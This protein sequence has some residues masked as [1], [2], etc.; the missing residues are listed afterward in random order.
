MVTSILAAS[1][2]E[3]IQLLS[4]P[5]RQRA[6]LKIQ[7]GCTNFCSYCII[8]YTRGPLRSRPLAGL[9]R[10]VHKLADAQFKEI[11]LTGIH[12]GA[13]GRDLIDGVTLADVVQAV[14]DVDGVVRIRLG[15]LE[16]IEV[17]VEMIELFKY[18]TKLCHHLHLPL[19]SGSNQILRSMNRPYTTAEYRSL[20]TNI[21][22]AVPDIA[23]STD[24]IVGFPGETE[25]LFLETMEFVRDMKF[26]KMHFFPYSQR[27]GTQAADFS[28]QVPEEVKKVR[29]HLMNELATEMSVNYAK[30]FISKTLPVLLETYGDGCSEGHTENYLK[31]TVATTD[32]SAVGT[33][34]NV[35]LTGITVDGLQG[36]LQN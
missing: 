11:V 29:A 17:S 19:Q 2:F 28:C 4:M 3:E 8:P 25:E 34:K 12:L 6:F 36:K 24:V 33:I 18:N 1:V 16:S 14:S 21:L 31:V 27:G 20:I 26:S 5:S 35:L 32:D 15:S 10:E 13:Y 9:L 23:I 7:E 30:R 22:S